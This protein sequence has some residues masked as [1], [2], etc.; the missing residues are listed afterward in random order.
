MPDNLIDDE[1]I[2]NKKLIEIIKT[3]KTWYDAGLEPTE[4]NFLYHENQQLSTLVM[5]IMEFPYEV[6]KWKE[7]F[8]ISVPTRED[9]YKQEVFSSVNYLKLRKIKRLINLNQKDQ[10]RSVNNEDQMALIQIH[11]HLKD[12][13][14]EMTKQMGTVILK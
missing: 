4:K 5:S 7:H 1:M 14:I 9:T 8:E 6:A 3:Y 2:D 12:L 10:E 11:K 13:E